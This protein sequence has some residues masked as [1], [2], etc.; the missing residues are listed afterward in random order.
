MENIIGR[1][2]EIR[3]LNRLYNSSIPQFVA[4]FGR[5][6]VGKTFLVDQTLKDRITFRHA[7]L[8]PVDYRQKKNF[9]K[10]QLKSFYFSL[11]RHGMKKSHCPTS[12]LE[13][14]FMLEMHL[15]STDDGSR[16]VVFLDELPWMDTPRSGF[17]T[18]L[19]SFWNGWGC[20]RDNFMLIV[21]GSATSWI[22]DN[23]VNNHGGLYGRLTC[24]MK[25]LPFTLRECE[26]LFKRN[27]VKLSRYDIVQSYMALGGIP[28]YLGYFESGM[29][30]AQNID[31]LFFASS[32]KLND[33]FDRLF[34]SVFSHPEDMK[35][36]VK[37]LSTRHVGYT[38]EDIA[39]KT[40]LSSGGHLSNSLKALM[41]SDFVMRYVPFGHSKREVHYKLIDPF[42]IF[43]LRYV[44]DNA[45]YVSSFW[46][47]NQ[48][49]QSIVSWRG[50]AFEE[51]C[52]L[53]INQIKQAMGIQ[54]VSS[55]QSSWAI[56]GN[57]EQEGTQ[58]D[59]IIERADHIVNLCEMKFYG[60]SFSVDKAYYQKMNYREKML[61]EK[62]ARKDIVH[63]ILVTTYGLTYNE[64]SGIFQHVI[65]LDDLF[66][67]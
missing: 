19:E 18:A 45:N 4:V 35:K 25:L 16:Q 10:E 3:E 59:L 21:C 22:M 5:R 38:M 17:I 32:A 46:Q 48:A 15:Q 12:W 14:F 39:T 50:F 49:S 13:A 56:T 37:L 34:A 27:R 54:G 6:R 2:K 53:H 42:C 43:Y 1:E 31:N 55:R 66:S 41:A 44:P 52:L 26:R 23:L 30:L 36:I 62:I 40:G 57:D 33:E 51:V 63:S 7:G 61:T 8:S 11:I 60:E 9:M 24:E 47:Q 58:I 64:Y 65:T 67:Q 20:H 29:S 28:Y